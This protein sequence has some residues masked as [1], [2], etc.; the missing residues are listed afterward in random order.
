MSDSITISSKKIIRRIRKNETLE[1]FKINQLRG[2]PEYNCDA[3]SMA[4]ILIVV[5]RTLTSLIEHMF[6]LNSTTSSST[7]STYSRGK[8]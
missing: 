4:Y 2:I 1:N 7:K 8:T 5:N 6:V 3:P